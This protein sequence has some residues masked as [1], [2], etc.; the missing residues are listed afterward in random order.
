METQ[1]DQVLDTSGTVCPVPVLRTL[2]LLKTM[3]LG[4]IL[5]VIVTD[6]GAAAD[7]SEWTDLTDREIV[8]HE[9]KDDKF[10]F[11]VRKIG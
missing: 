10:I 9:K 7:I 11:Y 1:A 5:K 6:P 3:R 8:A 4:Q 2:R